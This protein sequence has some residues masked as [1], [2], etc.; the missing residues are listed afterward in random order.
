[1]CLFS[2]CITCELIKIGTELAIIIVGVNG[3]KTLDGLV[4]E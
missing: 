4:K 1:M 3:D 2:D